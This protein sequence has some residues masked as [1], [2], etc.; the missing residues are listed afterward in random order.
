M[1]RR[2]VS[3]SWTR[4]PLPCRE[5]DGEVSTVLVDGR[6]YKTARFWGGEVWH[7][8]ATVVDVPLSRDGR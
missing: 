2:D 1:T 4:T 5:A 3:L 6:E 8:P 7:E